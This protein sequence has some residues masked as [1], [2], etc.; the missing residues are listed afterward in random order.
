MTAFTRNK[1]QKK[2]E[3]SLTFPEREWFE[4]FTGVCSNVQDTIMLCFGRHYYQKDCIQLKPTFDGKTNKLKF[5]SFK[6]V[7][8]SLYTHGHGTKI[9]SINGN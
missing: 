8:D 5:E 1:N 9:A 2:V 7:T 6:K 3:D 4:Y